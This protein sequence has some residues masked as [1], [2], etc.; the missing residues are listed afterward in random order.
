VLGYPGLILKHLVGQLRHWRFI[1]LAEFDDPVSEAAADAPYFVSDSC[2]EGGKPLV[3]HNKRFDLGFRK[4]R[5]VLESLLI[6]RGI[7]V[8]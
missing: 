6:Q 5:V 4:L 1:T 7:G 3:I 8:F 2:L